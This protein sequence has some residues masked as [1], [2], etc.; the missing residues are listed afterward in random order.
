[1][2]FYWP[3]L[4]RHHFL[5]IVVLTAVIIAILPQP[6]AFPTGK[7]VVNWINLNSRRIFFDPFSLRKK[8]KNLEKHKGITFAV[9]ITALLTVL[10][11]YENS[12]SVSLEIAIDH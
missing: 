4:M 1:M 2:K 6:L 5:L 12:A 8:H 11:L 9:P 10:R 3:I 7:S